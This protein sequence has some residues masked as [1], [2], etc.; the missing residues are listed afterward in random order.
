MKKIGFYLIV[1]TILITI[2]CQSSK[3]N[4]LGVDTSASNAS[5]VSEDGGSKRGKAA[6]IKKSYLNEDYQKAIEEYS[7]ELKE[8]P[9]SPVFNYY[10]AE[11]YRKLGK[12][13][14]SAPYYEKAIAG[15]YND[16]ELEI[17]YAKSLKANASYTEAQKVLE[18]YL[19]YA[20]VQKF[21][22][23]AERELSNLKKIDSLELGVKKIEIAEAK[24]INTPE[25]E[26]SPFT[27]NNEIYFAT[28]REQTT[29]ERHGVPFS[30]LYKAKFDGLTVEDGSVSKL[31]SS[32]NEAR[33]NEGSLAISP[34]GNTMVFAKGN[35]DDKKGRNH[36]N[37]FISTKK[38][39]KWSQPVLMPIN[40]PDS[41]DASPTF[42]RN[43]KTLYFASDRPGGYGGS[44]IYSA[45]LNERGRWGE[46]TNMGGT[47]NTA[48]DE[49]FPYISPDNKLYFASDGHIG[50]G[51]LD[52]FVAVRKS[53]QITIENMGPSINS[54]YDDFGIVYSDH[55]FEGFF[56]SNRP[57]GS[58]GDD[59]YTIKDDSPEHKKIEYVLRGKSYTLDAD[60]AQV[61]LPGVRVRLMT[62]NLE[63][64]DDMITGR[65]GIFEFPVDPEVE[66]VLIGEKTD[67]FTTRKD[68]STV[69]EGV[70]PE[71]LTERYLKKQFDSFVQLDPIV[72]DAT[73]VLENILYD[74][75]KADIR[76]DAA[77][78]LDKLVQLLVDNP[79]IKIELSSHTDSR[80]PDQ[81]NLDLSQRRAQSAVDYIVSKGIA[82]DRL[83][84]K[85]YGESRLVNGCSN[86]VECTEEQHQENRRT[87][88]KVTEYNK[89]GN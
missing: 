35:S 25:S 2:G 76:A 24:V 85:G 28:T 62:K 51:M 29:F 41:W 87:E 69:G 10:I 60:S 6:K 86:D 22:D 13:Y 15:G 21:I 18:D 70:N 77:A 66:Y 27:H 46:V 16:E 74:L 50:F 37:L 52:I 36:V 38:G 7:E 82:A 42:S 9:E 79:D 17:N 30:D 73:I 88:F 53:G 33:I 45:K 34:D 4:F 55:P 63:Q 23:R 64:V 1:T 20:T 67:F 49:V 89:E 68:F 78:E 40:S 65:G 57:G 80:A 32:F 75:N 71:D 72:K 12:V 61:T 59:I 19:D 31:P 26:Y 5:E 56:T 84:A 44:D 39:G 43:G 54:A 83:V 48:E 11:S 14:M 47:I 8:D 3:Q 81:Y 58:G